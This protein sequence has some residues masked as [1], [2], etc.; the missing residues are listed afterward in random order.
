MTYPHASVTGQKCTVCNLFS[1][2]QSK[3]AFYICGQLTA[4]I[5]VLEDYPQGYPRLA[6]F[7]ALDRD[8][9]VFKRFDYLHIRSLLEQ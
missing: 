9:T 2:L 7:L 4:N 6:A 8:F 1:V 3:G 5:S